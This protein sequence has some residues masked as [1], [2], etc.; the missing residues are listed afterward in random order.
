MASK[1]FLK[2]TY[3]YKVRFIMPNYRKIFICYLGHYWNWQF[4][5]L[6]LILSKN[7]VLLWLLFK[8]G[9]YLRAATNKD[10]SVC[11]FN[12]LFYFSDYHVLFLFPNSKDETLRTTRFVDSTPPT[13]SKIFKSAELLYPKK[14]DPPRIPRSE[15]DQ[16]ITFENLSDGKKR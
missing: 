1:C 14:K 4:F 12:F 5:A 9:Y 16:N 7:C 8:G 3:F 15:V 11:N 10:F 2:Q 6:N 13:W